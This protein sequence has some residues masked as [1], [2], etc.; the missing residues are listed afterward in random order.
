M[1]SIILIF[2]IGLNGLLYW[3]K[4]TLKDH[5]YEVSS[6]NEISC[7]FVKT[8]ANGNRYCVKSEI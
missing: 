7:T 6:C 8:K 3:I 4:F 1:R 2:L 5:G